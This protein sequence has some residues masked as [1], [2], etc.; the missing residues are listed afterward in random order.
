MSSGN[1]PDLFVILGAFLG[2]LLF[3]ACGAIV[4]CIRSDCGGPGRMRTRKIRSSSVS[5]DINDDK[6]GNIAEMSPSKVDVDLY[7]TSI[8]VGMDVNHQLQI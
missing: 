6:N 7:N 4:C 3:M 5:Q 1:H 2:A 8:E